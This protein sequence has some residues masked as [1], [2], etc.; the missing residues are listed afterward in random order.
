MGWRLEEFIA[1]RTLLPL[2]LKKIY[3]AM[4]TDS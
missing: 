2:L 4:A 1:R 3:S